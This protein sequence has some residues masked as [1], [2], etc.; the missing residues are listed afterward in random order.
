MQ[1]INTISEGGGQKAEI[2]RRRSARGIQQAEVL[3]RRATAARTAEW[4]RVIGATRVRRRVFVFF[5]TI[6]PDNLVVL[7]LET[8]VSKAMAR[9]TVIL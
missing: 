1:Q 3:K 4:E 7:T 9:F 6:R 2:S 8:L 5:Q